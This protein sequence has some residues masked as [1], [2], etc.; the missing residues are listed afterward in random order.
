MNPQLIRIAQSIDSMNIRHLPIVVK[1]HPKK[2]A[3]PADRPE[4]DPKVFGPTIAIFSKVMQIWV[5]P[6]SGRKRAH[7]RNK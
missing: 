2:C 6:L 1:S 7:E 3:R 5:S 4:S